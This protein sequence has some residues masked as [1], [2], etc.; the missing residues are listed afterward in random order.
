[1]KR[2]LSILIMGYILLAI[3]WWG[4]LL[5]IKN[6]NYYNVLLNQEKDSAKVE[7]LIEEKHD[8]SLMI[9]GE[10]IVLALSVL[11]GLW[12]INRSINREIV[13]INNQNNFLLSVSHE[14]KSPV[15]AI[16]LAIQTLK[17]KGLRADQKELLLDR[18][19]LDS[20]RLEKMIENVLITANFDNSSFQVYEEHIVI[21]QVISRI[22][23]EH[24]QLSHREIQLSSELQETSYFTDGAML[25]IIVDN[26]LENAVKYSTP[27]DAI[28]VDLYE[29]ASNVVIQVAD[30][31][32]GISDEDKKN[33]T[34]RFYRGDHKEVRKKKGTGL[35][36]YIVKRLTEKLKGSLIISDNTPKGTK[37]KV[38]LPISV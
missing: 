22:I 26:L 16:K 7:S 32:L 21:S 14:L 5:Y 9:I 34:E 11:L 3:S 29:D 37:I 12:L 17:R 23:E 10:G 25:R 2:W 33:V 30:Q 24:R 36:L 18:A 6:D 19:V 4:Y 20:D 13:S 1:M 31:G 35:G 27:D 15:A 38:K 28:K 8:Q